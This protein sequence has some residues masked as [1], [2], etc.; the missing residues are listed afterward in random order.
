MRTECMR[1]NQWLYAEGPTEHQPLPETGSQQKVAL[2][3][4]HLGLQP[5]GL[6][7]KYLQC[8]A[9]GVRYSNLDGLRPAQVV[10]PRG[11]GAFFV[12]FRAAPAAYGGSQDR[13]KWELQVLATARATA[14]QNPSYICNLYAAC[15]NARSL[16]Y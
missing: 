12:F 15:G 9:S 8:M 4:L 11:S 14:T 16:T 7:G 10:L 1:G 3:D 5:P 6:W 13:V 2:P